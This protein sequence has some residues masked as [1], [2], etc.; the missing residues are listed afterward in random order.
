[1]FKHANT[2]ISN[3]YSQRSFYIIAYKERVGLLGP[4]QAFSQPTHTSPTCIHNYKILIK[5][6]RHLNMLIHSL[7][8]FIVSNDFISLRIKSE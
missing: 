1:M 6:L 3:V 4:T 8:T 7:V 2:L 5:F